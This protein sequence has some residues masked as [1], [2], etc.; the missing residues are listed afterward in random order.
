MQQKILLGFILTLVIVIFIPV[1]WAM[2]SGRQEAALLRQQNEAV[3]RGSHTYSSLCASCHGVNGEGGV[4]PALRGTALDTRTLTRIISRGVPGTIM[5][6]WSSEDGGPLKEHQINDLVS[7]IKNWEG[8]SET[9]TP[10]EPTPPSGTGTAATGKQLYDANCAACHG[11]DGSGGLKIGEATAAD[12][13]FATL[14]DIYGGDWPIAKRA[15]LDGKDEDG[16]ELEAA[17]PRWRG[18]LSDENVDAIIDYLQT[19][20]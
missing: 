9:L 2:E 12:V 18:R 14:N 5:P 4:G 16:E 17:M 3:E 13:R 8:V 15:V 6:A 19:L 7:F 11:A 20:K 10:S 1:Y